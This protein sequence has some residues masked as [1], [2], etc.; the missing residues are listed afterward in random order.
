[1]PFLDELRELYIKYNL[2]VKSGN[3]FD[4]YDLVLGEYDEG[5]FN[6]FAGKCKGAEWIQES[7]Q[8]YQHLIKDIKQ[9]NMLQGIYLDDIA[10][11][12]L[13]LKYLY[14]QELYSKRY[15]LASQRWLEISPYNIE[16]YIFSFS[17]KVDERVIVS[18]MNKLNPNTLILQIEE[19]KIYSAVEY[20]LIHYFNILKD[21]EARI[22]HG[23]ISIN[24]SSIIE[25]S[26]F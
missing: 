23:Y 11:V 7:G 18:L 5:N 24:P 19:D 2:M 6:E 25:F 21:T 8:R 16:T 14:R 1:M 17:D 26:L 22:Y 20:A 4:K 13:V 15:Q 9:S 12:E 3:V 10:V